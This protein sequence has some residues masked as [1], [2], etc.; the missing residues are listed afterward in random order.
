MGDVLPAKG[1]ALRYKRSTLPRCRSHFARGKAK[2]GIRTSTRKRAAFRRGVA[3]GLV[4]PDCLERR[5][6]ARLHGSFVAATKFYVENR[7]R[8]RR[9]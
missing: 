3:A 2:G 6:A 1:E 8:P 7:R 5:R 9:P 4:T